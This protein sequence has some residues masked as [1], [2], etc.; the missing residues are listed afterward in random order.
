M[1][2]GP[3]ARLDLVE[4]FLAGKAPDD[5][6]GLLLPPDLESFDGLVEH[7]TATAR[8]LLDEGGDSSSE[9]R[10]WYALSTRFR[11]T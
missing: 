7:A 10:G 11:P 8:E 6:P 3:S 2:E 5:L 4:E 1:L 9:S